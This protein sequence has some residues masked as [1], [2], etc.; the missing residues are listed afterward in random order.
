MNS[1]PTAA[2]VTITSKQ[3]HKV[4]P[5]PL[6]FEFVKKKTSRIR[7]VFLHQYISENLSGLGLN[8]TPEIMPIAAYMVTMEEPP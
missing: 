1:L 4:E 7:E 6:G 2:L 3:H 5:G 8:F